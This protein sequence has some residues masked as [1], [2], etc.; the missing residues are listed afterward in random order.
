M[1]K[2]MSPSQVFPVTLR[3]ENNIPIKET[4]TN[5][6]G[7]FRFDNLP[8]NQSYRVGMDEEFAVNRMNAED[9]EFIYDDKGNL[10]VDEDGQPLRKPRSGQMEE[11]ETMEDFQANMTGEDG[12]KPGQGDMEDQNLEDFQANMS[13]EGERKK[14][15]V[16]NPSDIVMEDFQVKGS[17][18]EP[19]KVLFENIYFD[20]DS[21]VLRPEAKKVLKDL[22]AY[23]NNNENVQVEINAH[24]DAIGSSDY[25]ERL[26]KRRGQAAKNYLIAE[27]ADAAQ[28][29][30][31]ARGESESIASNKTPIGR[32][33]NRRVEFYILGGEGY[34]AE[35]MAYVIKPGTT[36]SEVAQRFNMSMDELKAINNLNNDQLKSYKPLRVRRTNDANIIAP[37]TLM[38]A[39]SPNSAGSPGGSVQIPEPPELQG[40][41][42]SYY[43]VERGETMYSIARQY[44]MTVDQLQ[45]M[46][47]LNSTKLYTG[48]KLR[49]KQVEVSAGDDEY[50][51]KE[52]DTL[53]SI[54]QQFDTTPEELKEL[55]S[56]NENVLYE[57]M[58]LKVK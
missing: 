47:N 25:N 3:D 48:Q 43:T 46:N 9:S 51:V 6:D 34:Q 20:F 16:G 55:N 37:V 39:Q 40:A 12:H 35:Y 36:I 58:V 28:I 30:V 10:V 45:E 44:N 50:I 7:Q 19:S 14:P 56:L 18:D 21:Y 52:G 11:D 38:D 13:E 33:L 53:Y 54:A 49:V 41:D 29:V 31:S 23:L 2:T 8:T 26:S 24:T 42:E 4:T 57:R 5:P 17:M 27:G 1:K 32:Q 15:S 22:V